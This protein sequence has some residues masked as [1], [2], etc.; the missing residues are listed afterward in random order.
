VTV[1]KIVASVA[2]HPCIVD[3][4]PASTLNSPPSPHREAA[5]VP[6]DSDPASRP[7]PRPARGDNIRVVRKLFSDLPVALNEIEA[8][9][10]PICS[11]GAGP[12]QV[13]VVGGPGLTSSCSR[14]RVQR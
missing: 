12:M 2:E 3:Q 7:I 5:Q 14:L 13:V 9:Y 8:T 4:L 11:L 6:I 10:G 1:I